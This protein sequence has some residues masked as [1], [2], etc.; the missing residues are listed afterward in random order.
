MRPLQSCRLKEACLDTWTTTAMPAMS[1]M[2]AA[3]SFRQIRNAD[4]SVKILH[5]WHA[6]AAVRELKQ[7]RIRHATQHRLRYV[8]AHAWHAWQQQ[9]SNKKYKRDLTERAAFHCIRSVLRQAWI[10]WQHRVGDEKKEKEGLRMA[11]MHRHQVIALRGLRGFIESL[12]RRYIKT[13]ASTHCKV[14]KQRCVSSVPHCLIIN[15]GA[16]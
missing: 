5:A 13:L 1:R 9:V 15:N 14:T 4:Q 7:T 12:H 6:Y 2:H 3:E 8:I 10:A 16:M 11:A